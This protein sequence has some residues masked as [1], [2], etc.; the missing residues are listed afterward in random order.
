MIPLALALALAVPA[1]PLSTNPQDA[2]P[3]VKT[4]KV[5]ASLDPDA[6][7]A[8]G[9][10]GAK[11]LVVVFSDFQCPVCR[12][13]ADATQQIAEEFPGDVRIEFWQRPLP[14]H[15]DAENAAVAALAAHRQGKFWEYHDELFRNQTALQPE[16]LAAWA[17]GVGLDPARFARDYADPKL[18]ER[19]RM[20]SAA[21]EELG[22]TSTPSF[23]VNGR[24][25]VGWGSWAGFRSDV[26]R[27]VVEARK[28]E[29]AGT[30]ADKIAAARADVVIGDAEQAGR[31]RSLVLGAGN[32]P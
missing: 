28:L 21:A 18:R 8:L 24:L 11:V 32:T 2:P 30:P 23:M 5:F 4:G 1:A 29:Q 14:N 12:R 26:E 31:Y 20:E 22:A 9:P 27:E 15:P 19:A 17:A 3:R 13:A 16:Q 10:A 25:R 7:P 6:R